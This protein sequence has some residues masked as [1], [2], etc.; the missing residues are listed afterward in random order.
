MIKITCFSLYFINFFRL[1]TNLQNI[2][3]FRS[4]SQSKVRCRNVGKALQVKR[5]T[6]DLKQKKFYLIYNEMY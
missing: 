2:H 5:Y 1:K 4:R 3:L 6:A